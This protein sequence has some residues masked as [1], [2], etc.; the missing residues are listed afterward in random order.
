MFLKVL[1]GRTSRLTLPAFLTG[2]KDPAYLHMLTQSRH[3]PLGLKAFHTHL[4]T[5]SLACP[6]SSNPTTLLLLSSQQEPWDPSLCP[7]SNLPQ[8][9]PPHGCQREL[10]KT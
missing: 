10:S 2:E 4:L 3:H 8:V 1:Q 9:H 6:H 7:L 5:P